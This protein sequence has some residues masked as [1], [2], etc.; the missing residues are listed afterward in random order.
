MHIGTA[1]QVAG[2]LHELQQ[3][4]AVDEIALVTITDDHDVRRSSYELLA[5]EFSLASSIA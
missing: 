1:S 3:R 5:D 2:G 4:Y